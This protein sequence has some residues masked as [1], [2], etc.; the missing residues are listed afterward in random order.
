MLLA[1][2]LLLSTFGSSAPATATFTELVIS[3]SALAEGTLLG[4]APK[5]ETEPVTLW[6]EGLNNWLELA[7][8]DA[9]SPRYG[10]SM[11]WE[12]PTGLGLL[13]GGRDDSFV[14]LNETWTFDARTEAWSRLSI[15]VSPEA[16]VHAAMVF[17]PLAGASVLFGGEAG[18]NRNDTWMHWPESRTWV[19]VTPSQSPDRRAGH[20]MAFVPELGGTLMFGGV[21]A[22]LLLNDTWLYNATE[23]RWIQIA[24]PS[25]P[26]PRRSHRMA[27]SIALA[28][29]LLFGG[30][31]SLSFPAPLDD[32]WLF[33]PSVL[34]WRRLATSVAPLPRRGHLMITNT[35]TRDVL[36]LGGDDFTIQMND[37]WVF[38]AALREWHLIRHLSRPPAGRFS[39][40]YFDPRLQAAVMSGGIGQFLATNRTFAFGLHRPDGTFESATLNIAELG[41]NL[42]AV[43]IRWGPSAR[44]P[45]TRLRGQIGSL[46]EQGLWNF[47][48]PDGTAS[49]FYEMA[50]GER[51][52]SGHAGSRVLR[53]RLYF[54]T[55]DPKASPELTNVVLRLEAPQPPPTPPSL[56]VIAP[57]EVEIGDPID[58]QAFVRDEDGLAWV[59]LTYVDV[60]DQ[61]EE[62]PMT[63]LGP[64]GGQEV[65]VAQISAQPAAGFV[66]IQVSAQDSKGAIAVYPANGIVSVRVVAPAAIPDYVIWVLAVFG[67]LVAMGVGYSLVYRKR[68]RGN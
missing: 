58:V 32:T 26:S 61:P 13:F 19:N 6:L 20:A 8:M 33:D 63:L 9:G 11:V 49:S 48:G 45:D 50:A 42:A 24:T 40:G 43:E 59:N 53:V 35:S 29:V 52:W 60:L 5:P 64:M 27:Y 57:T 1:L 10:A 65:W 66:A 28:S 23:S 44:P 46:G 67:A 36:L 3:G 62:I 14:P 17:D 7:A 68:K 31:E 4:V 18:K 47:V 34:S 56:L 21:G 55:T 39:S 54:E 38:R 2:S 41:P 30:D 25:A 51:V 12:P 37:T 16:R 22:T 15:P